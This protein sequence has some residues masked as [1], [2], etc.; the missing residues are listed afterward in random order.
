MTRIVK[1]SGLANSRLEDLR[2]YVDSL[3]V[4]RRDNFGL[5]ELV[6]L[7]QASKLLTDALSSAKERSA[8]V[9]EL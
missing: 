7:E 1:K 3:R 2:D 4:T 8:T 6:L 5:Y 9:E